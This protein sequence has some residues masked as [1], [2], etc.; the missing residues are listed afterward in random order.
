[1]SV[2]DNEV[3]VTLRLP[4]NTYRK[5]SDAAARAHRSVEEELTERVTTTL[6]NEMSVDEAL[7][8]AY[9]SYLSRMKKEGRQPH[10]TEE[11]WDQM[12][13]IRQEVADELASAMGS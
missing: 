1:M 11:L 7:N 4:R 13:R 12:N 5:V 2:M 6:T 10:T 9:Q 8:E 3:S